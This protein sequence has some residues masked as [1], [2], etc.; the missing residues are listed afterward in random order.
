MIPSWASY[1]EKTQALSYNK[2]DSFHFMQFVVLQ[3]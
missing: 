1:I 2:I 3:S